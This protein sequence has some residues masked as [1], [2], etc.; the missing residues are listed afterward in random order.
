MTTYS[1]LGP[2]G[3]FPFKDSSALRAVGWLGAEAEFSRGQVPHDFFAK[4]VA[5]LVDPWEPV[6]A[7]GIHR[8]ELCQFTGGPGAVQFAGTTIR[9]GASNLF[10]PG[11]GCIYVAPSLV[12]HY[13]DAHGYRP[14][15]EF[16]QA[17][18]RCPPTRSME[19][20]RLL[21]ANGGRS[22]MA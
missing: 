3:Y 7:F 20:K 4:L 15:E 16:V 1:D 12:V 22:L 18:L 19:F 5:L 11:A 13:I 2:I 8:C 14:P 9:L 6:T 17:V 21:L 10:V